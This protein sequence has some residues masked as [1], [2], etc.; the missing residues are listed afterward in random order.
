MDEWR[1]IARFGLPLAGGA[2][3]IAVLWLARHPKPAAPPAPL[4]AGTGQAGQSAGTAVTILTDFS[5]SF[6]PYNWSDRLALSRLADGIGELASRQWQAGGP[7]TITWRRIGAA[8]VVAPPVCPPIEFSRSLLGGQGS[9][10]GLKKALAGCA[11]AAGKLSSQTEA[12]T[13]ISGAIRRAAE[14][15]RDFAGQKVLVVFSDLREDPVPGARPVSFQLGG[16]SVLLVH[17]PGT[18]DHDPGRYFE[19][20]RA[21][22][23]LLQQRGAGQVRQQSAYAITQ[24]SEAGFLQAAEAPASSTAT[25]LIDF[26]D[27]FAG[28]GREAGVNQA[29]ALLGML[30]RLAANWTPPVVMHLG[31]TAGTAL[32]MQWMPP[33][34]FDPKLIPR[35]GQINRPEDLEIALDEMLIG[36]AKTA[37]AQT[38]ADLTGA[39]ALSAFGDHARGARSYLFVVSDLVDSSA[40]S[41]ADLGVK[42]DGC[43]AVLLYRPASADAANPGAYFSRI[44]QW[45]ERLRQA[46]A[47]SVCAVEMDELHENSLRKCVS[48]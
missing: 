26:K 28:G 3:L 45:R 35:P 16:A 19:R 29:R 41:L 33:V 23:R 24:Q 43:K 1:R 18:E 38:S 48:D 12:Y 27:R 37:A 7:V 14:S 42:L 8:S 32:R 21:W 6:A 5:A 17:R 34:I 4:R 46:G 15:L 47:A 31:A 39:I 36:L 30:S 40:A 2:L 25:V 9:V 22:A 44:Q 10:E 20:I 13:D 11:A